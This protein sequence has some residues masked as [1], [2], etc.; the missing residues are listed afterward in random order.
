MIQIFQKLWFSK[1]FFHFVKSFP[2]YYR[3]GNWSWRWR[4][5]PHD[6]CKSSG[7]AT[8]IDDQFQDNKHGCSHYAWS[9][10]FGLS[11]HRGYERYL[12]SISLSYHFFGRNSGCCPFRCGTISL[13]L[14][15]FRLRN[16]MYSIVGIVVLDRE[17]FV[18]TSRRSVMANGIL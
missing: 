12:P 13:V 4:L 8:G 17:W 14:A 18:S 16:D 3:C 11:R 9:W 6:C 2:W 7:A 1:N 5:F 10:Q 15:S